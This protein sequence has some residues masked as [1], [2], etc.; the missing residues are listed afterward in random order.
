MEIRYRLS[1]FQ[2]LALAAE[3]FKFKDACR[4]PY[5]AP[6]KLWAATVSTWDASPDRTLLM[7]GEALALLAKDL[8]TEPPP[9]PR[10]DSRAEPCN[11]CLNSRSASQWDDKRCYSSCSLIDKGRK[12]DTF[13]RAPLV[14]RLWCESEKCERA[15]ERERERTSG[16]EVRQRD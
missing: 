16:T 5:T 9:L 3:C 8:F 1:S 6:D 10:P 12:A 15:R 11:S 7:A 2:G 14:P 4:S 13:L